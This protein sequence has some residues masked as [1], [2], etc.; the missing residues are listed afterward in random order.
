MKATVINLESRPERMV[1]FRK[2]VFPFDVE[3]F[4]AFKTDPGWFGC[5]ESHIAAIRMQKELPFIVFED[6]C[7]LLQPWSVVELVMS[8]LPPD[9]DMLWL[10]ATNVRSVERYSNNLFRMKGAYCAHACIFNSQ[11]VVDYILNNYKRFMQSCEGTDHRP[12]IDVFYV[13]EVQEKFNCFITDPITAAQVVTY[14][15]IELKVNDYTPY[16]NNVQNI[17]NTHPRNAGR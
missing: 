5:T 13:C 11:R 7:V 17:F 12:V 15:D 6:D 4:S 14:S 9:W 3:R 8:Q 10:G 16:I 2:N 1:E